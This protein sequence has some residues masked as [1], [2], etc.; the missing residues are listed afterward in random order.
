MKKQFFRA[1][2]ILIGF[3]GILVL[4]ISIYQKY[5]EYQYDK[6]VSQLTIVTPDDINK[7]IETGEKFVLFTGRKTCPDCRQFAS[8]LKKIQ[9]GVGEDI[10]ILY[11]NSE[12]STDTS[13]Q[14]FRDLYEIEEV[15]S[16]IIF[17][18]GEST[19][20]NPE[21]TVLDIEDKIYDLK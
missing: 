10:P 14:L 1:A 6:V 9:V 7:K 20:L 21:S 19:V 17:V 5:P 12:D 4:G 3:I 16:L 15:P 11:L 18:N 2:G 13:I 8:K